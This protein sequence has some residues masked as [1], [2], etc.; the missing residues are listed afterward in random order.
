MFLILILYLL[1]VAVFSKNNLCVK[2]DTFFKYTV[3]VYIH[4]K[5]M[6]FNFILKLCKC[7]E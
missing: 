4:I 3:C 5:N 1:F 7:K 2:V 6:E